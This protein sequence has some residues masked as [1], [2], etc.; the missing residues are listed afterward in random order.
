M[1]R[2]ITYY[3]PIRCDS[4]D[5]FRL[6]FESWACIR[7]DMSPSSALTVGIHYGGREER[8]GAT[9]KDARDFSDAWFEIS[10]EFANFLISQTGPFRGDRA[11]EI[12]EKYTRKSDPVK[13][14]KKEEPD[15]NRKDSTKLRDDIF[16]DIFGG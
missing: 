10:E 11:T 9:E 12:F 3:G 6:G 1:Y 16:R 5:R 2:Y 14:A 13:C 15:I 7:F 8:C 4:G